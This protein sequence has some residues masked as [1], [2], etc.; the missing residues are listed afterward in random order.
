[1]TRTLRTAARSV[2]FYPLSGVWLVAMGLLAAV[3]A[4][5]LRADVAV[6]LFTLTVIAI[7]LTATRAEVGSTRAEVT[8]IHVLVNSQHDELVATIT[9]MSTRIGQLLRA[10]RTADVPVPHDDTGA[11]DE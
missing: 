5:V 4:R 3:T 1:M 10:L 9:R 8:K 7:L 11:D 2:L 6:V